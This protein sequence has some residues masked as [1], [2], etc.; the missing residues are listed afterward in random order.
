[1]SQFLPKEE[2]EKI[3]V[4]L[5]AAVDEYREAQNNLSQEEN[6]LEEE[7]IQ[8]LEKKKMEDVKKKL[9]E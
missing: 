9:Y 5:R 1:M 2:L 3:E 8:A 4:D 6:L 7:F